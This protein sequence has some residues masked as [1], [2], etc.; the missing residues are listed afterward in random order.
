MAG[1]STF[2][3]WVVTLVGLALVGCGSTRTLAGD[4]A[5]WNDTLDTSDRVTVV[6]KSG[7]HTEIRYETVDDG[8]LYGTLVDGGG[9]YVI[10]VDE[11]E[12]LDVEAPGSGGSGKTLAVI[13]LVILGVALIDALQDIPPGWPAYR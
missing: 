5:S 3:T 12:H 10:A 2:R 13:G 6:E 1:T 7:Q 11:I 8:M 4:P 9:A